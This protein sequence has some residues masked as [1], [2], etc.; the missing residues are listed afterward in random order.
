MNT[1]KKRISILEPIIQS[2]IIFSCVYAGYIFTLTYDIIPKSVIRLPEVLINTNDLWHLSIIFV[3]VFL[4]FL[5]PIQ[6]FFG[7]G[8]FFRPKRFA[9]EYLVYLCA[10]TTASMYVFLATTINYDPQLIAAIGL[11]STIVYF[12]MLISG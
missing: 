3:V 8:V 1:S 12:L 2:L 11:F 6:F 7:R 10:Y 4:V 9:Q 5:I